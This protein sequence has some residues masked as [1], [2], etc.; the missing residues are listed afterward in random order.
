MKEFPFLMYTVEDSDVTVNVIIKDETIWLSQKQ[1]RQLERAVTGYFDYIEDLI[2]RENTFTLEKFSASVN[3]F[4]AFRRYEVLPDKSKGSVSKQDAWDKAHKE[5]DMFNKT[6]VIYSD[7]DDMVRE[8][9]GKEEDADE[10][11]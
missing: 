11:T 8:L 2:E 9:L 4:L 10:H 6:Q 5:Y 3:E 1:I 7:F